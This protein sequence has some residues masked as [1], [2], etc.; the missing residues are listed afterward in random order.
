TPTG[1]NAILKL[2][3]SSVSSFCCNTFNGQGNN[4]YLLGTNVNTKLRGSTFI[5]GSLTFDNTMIGLN[6]HAGNRWKEST[7]GRLIG[8]L[9]SDNQFLVNY[10]ESNS[11]LGD[12][13]PSIIEPS[14]IANEWFSDD[15]RESLGCYP[16]CGLPGNLPV[17]PDEDDVFLLPDTT[18]LFGNC[19]PLDLDTDG[20]GICDTSD[21]DAH[22]PCIPIMADLDNDGICDSMDPDPNNPCFP[23]EIDTDQDG[24]CD[25][26]DPDPYDFCI[27]NGI[28]TDGDGICDLIDLDPFNPISNDP[29]VDNCW[30]LNDIN[31]DRIKSLGYHQLGLKYTIQ[32]L[33]WIAQYFTGNELAG[34]ESLHYVESMTFLYEVLHTSPYYR[35]ISPIL[36]NKYIELCESNSSIP[37]FAKISSD[38]KTVAKFSKYNNFSYTKKQVYLNK[39]DKLISKLNNNNS[40]DSLHLINLK[41]LR[42]SIISQMELI[43]EQQKLSKLSK[44]EQLSLDIQNLPEDFPVY[45]AL[46]DFYEIYFQHSILKNPLSENQISIL[47]EMSKLCPLIYGEAV[48]HA[49]ALL[50]GSNLNEFEDFSDECLNVTWN[51]KKVDFPNLNNIEISPNPTNDWV[52]LTSNF[53][54]LKVDVV[55][56]HGVIIFSKNLDSKEIQVNIGSLPPAM[57]YLNI[58]TADGH[59]V[60]HKV[61]KI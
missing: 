37:Y 41:E 31:G 7:T 53:N 59:R 9:P 29:V 60:I 10:N 32:D 52:R 21:P 8:G 61:I 24:I 34:F 2:S 27:P 14:A 28:D 54:I 57:Y 42:N 22:D 4:L 17:N 19:Y 48:H 23:I 25:G 6:E 1:E 47:T 3:N 5:N 36:N 50:V 56:T 43:I 11:T 18:N 39:I 15:G 35:M 20:D 13:K 16:G 58:H 30:W 12:I 55:N 44:L 26:S 33:E 40:V 45:N 51:A 49:R 46:K 38:L